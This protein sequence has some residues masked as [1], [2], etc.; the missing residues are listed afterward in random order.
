MK[1]PRD[2]YPLSKSQCFFLALSQH[3]GRGDLKIR[4]ALSAGRHV[5]DTIYIQIS[6]GKY[7]T[8]DTQHNK[9]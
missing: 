4:V 1:R 9:W 2:E 6:V 3:Q 7:Q 5:S 8:V